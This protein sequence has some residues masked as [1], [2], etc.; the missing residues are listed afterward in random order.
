MNLVIYGIPT[1]STCTKARRWLNDRGIT[2][3]W[4]NLRDSA[5]SLEQC[6]QWVKDLTAAPLKN[7]S[8]GS[9]RALGD[10][11]RH[12]TDSEWA[13]AFANDPMLLKRPIVVKDG[14]A[15]FTGF[16]GSDEELSMQLDG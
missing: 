2:H 6:T 4:V 11:K 7:T 15:I 9:Y 12:W 10:E 3:T 1:C 14:H 5:P 8:G 13:T 16:K